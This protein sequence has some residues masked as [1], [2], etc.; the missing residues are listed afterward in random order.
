M[1]IVYAMHGIVE[2]HN[3]GYL[4]HFN[5]ISRK[6]FLIHLR[7]RQT[8]YVRLEASLRGEGD[9]LTIDDATYAALDAAML[10]RDYGH[11]VT[12]FIN[13]NNVIEGTAHFFAQLV[14]A[15]DKAQLDSVYFLGRTF[16]LRH[17]EGRR[18]LRL[19][20]KQHLM[21][22]KLE[23]DRLSCVASLAQALELNE[24]AIPRYFQTL[25]HKSLDNIVGR[26]IRIGNHGWTH[27]AVDALTPCCAKEEIL[28]A[29]KWIEH[30]FPQNGIQYAAPFGKSQ[31]PFPVTP[32]ICSTWLLCDHLRPTGYLGKNVF[33]RLRL[34]L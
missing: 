22:L 26:G 31:P 34:S 5:F 29:R 11:E 10:A 27:A 28:R 23:E 32:E 6:K 7:T 15:I 12:L 20:V 17:N 24:I 9:A 1:A 21:S 14:L 3:S 16:A 4:A 19:H 33:N 8:A 13:P 30:H 2:K 25:D 18:E